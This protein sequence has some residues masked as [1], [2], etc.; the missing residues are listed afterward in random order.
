MAGEL[1]DS[2]AKTEAPDDRRIYGVTVAQVI[3][4]CDKTRQGRVQV[5]LP[6]L[7]GFEPW[8]RLALLDQGAYFMP[9]V[10]DEVLVAFNHG[11][12]REPYIVGQLWNGLDHPPV[13]DHNDPNNKRIIRT[14]KG[15]EIVFDDQDQARSVVITSADQHKITL[16]PK[17][18]KISMAENKA[19]ITLDAGGNITIKAAAS[20]TLDAPTINV[21]G[22]N[23][24]IGGR[25]S[26]RIDGGG[27]CSI[28]AGQIFIG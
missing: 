24:A 7:P 11:D 3:A 2:A 21:M 12:V 20:I 13:R 4:N 1:V 18:V 23:V 8:A 19:I 17:E 15:H 10:G 28:Q 5:R 6:W 25:Q 27:H 16:S 22:D 26:A 14:P 9:Q